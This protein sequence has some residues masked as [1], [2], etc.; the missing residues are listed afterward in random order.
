MN[1][2]REQETRVSLYA[3][4]IIRIKELEEEIENLR[5]LVLCLQ[6]K[7]YPIKINKL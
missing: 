5:E 7:L 2:K 4:H 6:K 1:R 3:D